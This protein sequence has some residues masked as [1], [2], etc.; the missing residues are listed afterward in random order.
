MSLLRGL[1]M[2]LVLP[3]LHGS[4]VC[5]PPRVFSEKGL[6]YLEKE[7]PKIRFKGKGHEVST[8]DT[9]AYPAEANTSVDIVLAKMELAN[10]FCKI[11]NKRHHF[12]H[13]LAPPPP[14]PPPEARGM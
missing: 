11:S 9:S 8:T 1:G 6:P 4:P 5:L 13:I 12:K 7:F 10:N 2:G 3:S 14:P